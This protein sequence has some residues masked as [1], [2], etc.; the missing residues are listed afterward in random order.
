MFDIMTLLTT[1]SPLFLL[2]IGIL[3]LLGLYVVFSIIVVVQSRAF[4]RIVYI[5]D[6]FGSLFIQILSFLHLIISIS[7]FLLALAIL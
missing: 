1:I 5:G 7:L 6:S 4:H 2:R 3:I